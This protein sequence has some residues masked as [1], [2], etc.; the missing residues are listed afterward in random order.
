VMLESVAVSAIGFGGAAW[1]KM[2]QNMR[3][4]D[5]L[6]T[7]LPTQNHGFSVTELDIE[8]LLCRGYLRCATSRSDGVAAALVA[9]EGVVNAKY[10]KRS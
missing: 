8:Q 7:N 5:T 3:Q 6:R 9:G 1:S 10:R 4:P 2:P